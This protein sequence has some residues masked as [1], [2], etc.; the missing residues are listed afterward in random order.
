MGKIKII[1]VLIF[2]SLLNS[3]AQ[4]QLTADAMVFDRYEQEPIAYANIGFKGKDWGGIA[5]KDGYFKIDLLNQYIKE[6]DTLV[7]SS[8]GYYDWAIPATKLETYFN[9]QEIVLLTPLSKQK[10]AINNENNTNKKTLGGTTKNL[11]A[12]VPLTKVLLFGSEL[13][14]KI[15]VPYE[16]STLEKVYFEVSENST[17]SVQLR[18]NIYDIND[19]M[20]NK[21]LLT[22][23]INH[24]VSMAQG[25]DS[26]DLSKDLI[27]VDGDI[28]V[29]LQ[30]IEVKGDSPEIELAMSNDGGAVFSRFNG[31]SN[32]VT[33]PAMGMAYSVEVGYRENFP[34][35]FATK[36]TTKEEVKGNYQK[37]L[38][39]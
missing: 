20:P 39:K 27:N 32:W 37:S 13:A 21:P 9:K 22:K 34:D 11:Y 28:V 36:T 12:S 2:F 15:E 19:G 10:T 25:K 35:S 24:W 4:K 6:T 33:Y 5:D 23:P 31:Q 17:D 7:I 3:F 14:S 30:L 16:K 38:K 26:I 29:S 1:T 18:L 8:T